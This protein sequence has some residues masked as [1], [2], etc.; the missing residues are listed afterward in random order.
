VVILLC[1]NLLLLV[2]GTLMDMAALLLILTPILLPVVKAV[3]V[4]PVHFGMIMIVNLGIGLLTPP[5]GSVL[6]VGSAVGKLPIE[7]VVRAL[8]PF[9]LLLL[10]VLGIVTFVP[11]LSLWLPRAMGL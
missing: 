7:Q 6:F 3:G 1:I 5:V 9:F 11:S 4:D 10:V 8:M 2:L